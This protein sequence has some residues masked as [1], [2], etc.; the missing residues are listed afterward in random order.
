[1]PMQ[2]QLKNMYEEGMYDD[3]LELAKIPEE[4]RSFSAWDYY[5][6]MN[7]AYKLKQYDECLNV[8]RHCKQCFPEFEMLN[9]KCGWAL[10]HTHIKSFNPEVDDREKYK[11]QL[12]FIINHCEHNKYSPMWRA[13]KQL[14]K[15]YKS[16]TF[17]NKIDYE[18]IN[19]CL[20]RVNP[21]DLSVQENVVNIGG[22]TRRLA[23]DRECWYFNKIKA[24]K[25]LEKNEECIGLV[26]KA[27]KNISA[28]HNNSNMWMLYYAGCSFF[29]LQEY[30]K[31]KCELKKLLDDDFEHFSVWELLY[32]INRVEGNHKEAVRCGS[33]CALSDKNHQMRVN[34]YP[35]F[36]EYLY[37]QGMQEA[38]MMHRQLSIKLR[39]E[40][41]WNAKDLSVEW[42]VDDK[43]AAMNACELLKSLQSFWR[44]QR[45]AGLERLHGKVKTLL[46]TGNC[47]FITSDDGNDYY[48]Q[49][50]DIENRYRTLD[51]AAVSFVIVDKLDK[52][53]NIMKKNA[54]RIIVE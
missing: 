51:N 4:L 9:D 37:E 43:I 46:P 14:I 32:K 25:M 45:D 17:G 7:A 31:A 26:D 42:S 11:K 20:D 19:N 16:N 35:E 3:I 28:F 24:L 18:V 41:G 34:F 5:Y 12:L 50:R 22:K 52:K 33:L 47:G 6:Y 54:V 44:E 1:M 2:F 21:D 36:A 48:F 10:Y 13:I 27:M 29:D 15:A 40:N 23:S 8:Y 30:A 39:E 38:A 53:K 49:V